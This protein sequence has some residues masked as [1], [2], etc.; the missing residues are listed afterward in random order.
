MGG[1]SL[2]LRVSRQLALAGLALALLGAIPALGAGAF[3]PVQRDHWAYGACMRLAGLGL[4]PAEQGAAFSGKQTLTRFEFALAIITPLDEVG[5]AVAALPANADPRALRRL[6][7]QAL[8]LSPV[9]AEDE[10]ARAA[11][12]LVRLSREFADALRALDFDPT[13]ALRGIGTLDEEGVRAWRAE[14]LSIPSAAAALAPARGS[15]GLL[16]DALRLPLAHGTVAFTYDRDAP[17]PRLLDLFAAASAE[18]GARGENGTGA[19]PALRDPMVSRLRTAYEYGL[20]SA[21]TLSLAYEEVLRRGQGL[22]PLDGASL[23]SLGIGYRLTPSASLR[24]S[25]SLLEYANHVFDTPPQRDR[26]AE[27]AVSIAF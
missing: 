10:V 8:R 13:A 26:V 25:Y 4:L 3:E 7:A 1:H 24:L 9:T 19:E 16:A 5:T 14:A 11:A 15:A 23:A 18:R 17:V 21:L 2:A 20:G 22:A 12:D 27:T 6:T